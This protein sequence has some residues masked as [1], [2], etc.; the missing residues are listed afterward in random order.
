MCRASG[1]CAIV[2]AGKLP[3]IS[4]EVFDLIAQKCVPGGSRENLETANTFTKWKSV[5]DPLKVLSADAQT[6]G[7]LLLCVPPRSLDTVLRLLKRYKT[8]CA[9][10]IGKIERGSAGTIT[11]Q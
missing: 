3:V 5:A 10:V 2:E 6:S 8:A 9:A 4:P 1:V 7:G 11:V